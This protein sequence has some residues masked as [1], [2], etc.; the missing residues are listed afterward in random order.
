M[1]EAIVD[2]DQRDDPYVGYFI[3][4]T[5]IHFPG[6]MGR[7]RFL[8][9]AFRQ[10]TMPLVAF[11]Q[12]LLPSKSAQC[13]PDWASVDRQI[14][15]HALNSVANVLGPQPGCELTPVAQTLTNPSWKTAQCSSL[16]TAHLGGQ[17][18]PAMSPSSV[19]PLTN[20]RRAA[21]RFVG[22]FASSSC[23][24]VHIR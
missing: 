16:G 23:P 14:Q 24:L 10:V 5:S 3:M 7:T 22:Q 6:F 20:G 21:I 8:T 19:S 9:G 11:R 18:F 12:V 2:V 17:T 4:P 1:R 15:D 13:W